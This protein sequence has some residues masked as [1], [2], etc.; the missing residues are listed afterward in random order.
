ML[1]ERPTS[2]VWFEDDIHFSF[3]KMYSNINATT[4]ESQVQFSR[5]IFDFFKESLN[6]PNSPSSVITLA[7]IHV[8]PTE[9]IVIPTQSFTFQF[10]V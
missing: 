1:P 4:L 9:E 8:L 7:P 6:H 10:R 5:K 2:V 3:P